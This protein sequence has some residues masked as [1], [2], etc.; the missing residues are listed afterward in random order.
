[1]SCLATSGR[2][3]P[4]LTR[5]FASHSPEETLEQFQANVFGPLNVYRAVLPYLRKQRSGVLATIG[6]MAAWYADAGASL[7]HSSKAAIRLIAQGLQVETSAIGIKH[8]LIEPGRFR[9]ELLSPTANN[10]RKNTNHSIDD[11][12][13][14]NKAVGMGLHFFHGNQIGDPEKA[15][16]VIYD[17][18]TSSGV[19]QGREIP[20]TLALGSDAVAEI[21]KSAQRAIDDVKDWEEVSLSTNFPK[22]P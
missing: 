14:L 19:A 22:E 16:A 4:R 8:C 1:M 21:I 2:P 3:R 6:S 15:A 20:A 12:A 18:L 10:L 9:T 7:Y 17:V 13:E 5:L 11:Y